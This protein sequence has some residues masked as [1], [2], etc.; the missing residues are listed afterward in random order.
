MEVWELG[1]VALKKIIL[2]Q[3]GCTLVYLGLK[4]I[5]GIWQLPMLYF[6]ID[7]YL[8]AF[9]IMLVLAQVACLT[10]SRELMNKWYAY[11]WFGTLAPLL[12]GCFEAVMF[13]KVLNLTWIFVLIGASAL[14]LLLSAWGYASRACLSRWQLMLSTF[15]QFLFVF[16]PAFLRALIIWA[17]SD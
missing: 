11:G 16:A 9:L 15:V 5:W 13:V 10:R 3:V 14:S 2:W 17:R 8:P 12:A 1:V 7:F 6:W 4:V